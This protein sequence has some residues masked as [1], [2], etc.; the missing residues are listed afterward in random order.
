[1]NYAEF[2]EKIVSV[3]GEDMGDGFTVSVQQVI[4]RNNTAK[5]ALI[6]RKRSRGESIAP[7]IF[8]EPYFEVYSQGQSMEDCVMRIENS[9]WKNAADENMAR[10]V[11]NTASDWE[12]VKRHVY[13]FLI[14]QE[15]N[16]ELLKDLLY[17]EFLD[18][19][20]CYMV[21][22]DGTD[23]NGSLNISKALFHS[24][25]VSREELHL[26]ALENMKKDG[27][28]VTGMEEL[29]SELDPEHAEERGPV[30]QECM[31]IVTNEDKMYGAAGMLLDAYFLTCRFGMRNFYILPSSIHEVILV[32]DGD[33][34]TAE[35]LSHMVR[36]VNQGQVDPEERLS[37]HVYYYDWDRREIQIVK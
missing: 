26:Y 23:R 10:E 35:E 6:I 33:E 22:F 5:D 37:N 8:L 11:K 18:L 31:Y 24:W 25:G 36:D 28:R 17:K 14:S 30:S 16:R 9:Y 7:V 21:R 29:I 4:K 32:P 12:K 19:A 2:I 1:M 15:A 20:V 27:Y 3:V 13:P 34:W